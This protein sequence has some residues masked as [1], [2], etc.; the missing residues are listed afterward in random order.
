MRQLLLLLWLLSGT[1]L[2]QTTT[3]TA[4]SWEARFRNPA[5]TGVITYYVVP[6]GTTDQLATYNGSTNK[7]E[8]SKLGAGLS[9]AG[10]VL[11]IAPAASQISDSTA[12]GRAVL[13][14]TDAAAARTAIGA[15]TSSFSGAYGD[16][17]G[18]PTTFAP[19]AHTQAWTTITSTPTTLDG[20]GITDAVRSV[21]AGAGLSGGTITGSG[22]ISLP[23][24]GT[25][26]SYSGVTTDAQGRV[27]AGTVRSFAYQTRAL[28]TC[29]Q[30]SATRDAFVSYSVDIAASIA[31][32]NPGAQGT[33]YLRTYTNNTCSAGAQEIVRFVNG[34]TGSAL[35]SLTLSQ[36]VTGTLTGIIP[37]GVW[38]QLVTENNTGTPTFTARPGQEVLL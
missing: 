12:T 25:A 19:A 31:L 3:P 35:G 18:I 27:T 28:N 20:Y 24:T 29:F 15:G 13:T 2:A 36:N 23:S 8:Y 14:A 16:L 34:N 10:N 33:V 22:T 26:G 37:A 30:I 32:L 6:D 7:P 1:A 9:R 5:N 21:T 38:L 11:N 4:D 17:A